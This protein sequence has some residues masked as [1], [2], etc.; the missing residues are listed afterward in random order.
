[1]RQYAYPDKGG[2]D[3]PKCVTGSD[4]ILLA[5]VIA[6]LLSDGLSVDEIGILS[7]LFTS[8]GD[9][10]AIIAAKKQLCES[11]SSSSDNSQI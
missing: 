6:I 1:M 8:I 11:S 5:A 3:M 2:D 9:N 7:G 10:L 4:F